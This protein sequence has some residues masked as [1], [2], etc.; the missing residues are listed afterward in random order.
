MKKSKKNRY[1][2]SQPEER[3]GLGTRKS[4]Y[5]D[6]PTSHGGWPEGEYD[7]P[8]NDRIFNYLKDMGLVQ[9]AH[10]RSVIRGIIKETYVPDEFDPVPPANLSNIKNK[11][12][13]SLWDFSLAGS[14]YLGLSIIDMW[15]KFTDE[16]L[17]GKL[18]SRT[19]EF[20]LLDLPD[21]IGYAD[22]FSV[23]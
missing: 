8:I 19:A 11:F 9:E 13:V 6:R 1:A 20:I 3:Y 14:K 23:C 5:L 4:L 7:P 22:W 17:T 10:L 15:V 16:L 2:G 12:T 21:L 18:L